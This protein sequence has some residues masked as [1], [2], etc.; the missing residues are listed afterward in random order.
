[1]SYK[2]IVL[3]LD[4]DDTVEP[5]VNMAAALGEEFQTHIVGVHSLPL[6]E[7]PVSLVHYLPV[8]IYQK[9]N[10]VNLARAKKIESNF[11]QAMK[12]LNMQGEWVLHQGPGTGGTRNLIDHV[13]TSDLVILSQNSQEKTPWLQRE[14]LQKTATPMMVVPS[15]GAN[16]FN[17]RK[18]AI[19]WNGSLQTVRAIRD[20]MDLLVQAADVRLVCVRGESKDRPGQISGSDAATW[21]SHHGIKVTLDEHLEK[22]LTTGVAIVNAAEDTGAD[23]LV[24]GGYGHSSLYDVV[25]GGVTDDVLTNADIP[26]FLSH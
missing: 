25:V 20:S 18:I 17:P 19:A 12:A 21:L 2:L 11:E 14:L 26:V 9:L 10:D 3:N 16:D 15:S 1:M 13:R 5:L 24:I 23:L 6:V 7:Q 22:R 8:D 4:E